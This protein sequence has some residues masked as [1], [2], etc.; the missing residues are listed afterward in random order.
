MTVATDPTWRSTEDGPVHHASMYDGEIYD[1]RMEQPGWD[2]PG[3]DD[4]DWQGARVVEFPGTQ[5]DLAA[6]RIRSG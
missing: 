1:A 2:R 5:L 6:Q 4:A 3:F